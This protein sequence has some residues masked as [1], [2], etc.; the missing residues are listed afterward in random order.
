MK[1]YGHMKSVLSTKTLV[2]VIGKYKNQGKLSD[3]F[4][5]GSPVEMELLD[6]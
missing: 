3:F 4:F 1:F 5:S 2:K 6:C